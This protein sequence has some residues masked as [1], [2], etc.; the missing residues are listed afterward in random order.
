MSIIMEGK[1][2]MNQDPNENKKL[3]IKNQKYFLITEN[4]STDWESFYQNLIDHKEFDPEEELKFSYESL[5]QREFSAL[6]F[7]KWSS[8]EHFAEKL[9]QFVLITPKE[10]GVTRYQSQHNDIQLNTLIQNANK[11]VAKEIKNTDRSESK[12]DNFC[13]RYITER[14]ILLNNETAL[15]KVFFAR[16]FVSGFKTILFKSIHYFVYAMVIYRIISISRSN[17]DSIKLIDLFQYLFSNS[18]QKGIDTFVRSLAKMNKIIFGLILSSPLLVGFVNGLINT[19]EVKTN[20]DHSKFKKTIQEINEYLQGTDNIWRDFFRE[21]LPLV[22]N[23]AL[24]NKIQ[25][26]ER[27]ICWDGRLI[28]NDRKHAF[29]SIYSLAMT[30]RKSIKITAIESLAKIAHG[31]GLKDLERLK[32]LGCDPL[33]LEFIIYIKAKSLYGLEV[34]ANDQ[35]KRKTFFYKLKAIFLLW[36]LGQFSSYRQHLF[37]LAKFI[38]LGSELIFLSTIIKSIKDAIKCTDK[39]GYQFGEGYADWASDYNEECF[40][41]RIDFFRSIYANES[42]QE[43]LNEI[44]NY[45]LTDLTALDLSYKYLT[46]SEASAIIQAVIRQGAIIKTLYLHDNPGL[47]VSKNLFTGMIQLQNLYLENNQ[48]ND[49]PDDVF[50]YLTQLTYLRLDNNN[51]K[52]LKDGTFSYLKNLQL[53]WLERNQLANLNPSAFSIL[54]KLQTLDLKSN[55][56]NSFDPAIWSHFPRLNLLQLADNHMNTTTL[57]ETLPLLPSSLTRLDFSRNNID[58]LPEDFL[59]R[60]PAGI[61][62]LTI[63]GNFVP[64]T[65]DGNFMMRYFRPT[66]TGVGIS[67][68]GI[69]NISYDAFS[70]FT[71]LRFLDLSFNKL[72]NNDFTNEMFHNLNQLE[73]LLLDNNFFDSVSDQMFLGLSKLRILTIIS[74]QLKNIHEMAFS[75]LNQLQVLYLHDNQLTHLDS[76]IFST[77]GELQYL[78][79]R[80]N[81]LINL[82]LSLFKNLKK[83]QALWLN[84]N[85]LGDTAISNITFEFP[86]QLV[87]LYLA[88]NKITNLGA[89]I[90]SNL[91]PCTYI[92]SFTFVNNLINDSSLVTTLQLNTLKRVCDDRLCHANLAPTE[93]CKLSSPSTSSL[94]HFFHPSLDITSLQCLIISQHENSTDR[95]S[96]SQP[97]F[98]GMCTLSVFSIS[99]VLYKKRHHIFDIGRKILQNA[100]NFWKKSNINYPAKR[101]QSGEKEVYTELDRNY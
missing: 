49:L 50:S 30:G 45:H 54:E 63:G 56:L 2:D 96:F 19:Q 101:T 82:D 36:W 99:M 60:L 40:G 26:L 31:I 77:Q 89:D 47:T 78:N 44:P 55:F 86:D 16:G 83:L 8:V 74:N 43:L 87:A 15:K 88:N 69:L 65:I 20:I 68:S 29:E 58:D 39:D 5:Y 38:G 59:D 32:S 97:L 85:T 18:S 3:E 92:T 84:N 35:W 13:S 48:I 7:I 27:L 34:V 46:E 22:S 9:L 25:K 100:S 70:N 79:L 76:K 24:N 71:D 81:Q 53:L 94:P 41:G 33:L 64:I 23:N 42:L 12:A 6:S 80:N 66:F 28:L 14:A 17:S 52:I 72:S 4:L 1:I 67:G 75:H 37:Y 73:L 21:E 90:L 62:V 61:S 93:L 10:F 98:I 11:T 91:L 57:M 95:F 51:L